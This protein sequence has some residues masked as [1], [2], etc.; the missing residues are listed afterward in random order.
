MARQFPEKISL[1]FTPQQKATILQAIALSD[2]AWRGISHHA[3]AAVLA[4]ANVELSKAR[5]RV[6]RRAS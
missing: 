3:R 2:E 4:W 5:A 6:G 1:R